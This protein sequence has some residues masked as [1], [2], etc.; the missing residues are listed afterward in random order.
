MALTYNK[1]FVINCIF[2]NT[3]QATHASGKIM[4]RVC[5]KKKPTAPWCCRFCVGVDGFEPPTLC[6]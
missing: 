5:I 3:G 4:T 6:L 2:I 1:K